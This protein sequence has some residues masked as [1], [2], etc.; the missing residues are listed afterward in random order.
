LDI[1]YGA[2]IN[3]RQRTLTVL[4]RRSSKAF[5]AAVRVSATT[6]VSV[7]DFGGASFVSSLGF[8]FVLDGDDDEAEGALPAFAAFNNASFLFFLDED[9]EEDFLGLKEVN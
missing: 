9:D 8:T 6:T 4:R 5:S 3:N 7:V 1:D 2:K